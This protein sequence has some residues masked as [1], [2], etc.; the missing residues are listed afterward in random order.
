MDWPRY[1]RALEATAIMAVEDKRLALL[2]G[3][4]K[5][6]TEDEWRLIEEHERILHDGQPH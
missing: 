5:S 4:V 2:R 3:D 6:M 1:L